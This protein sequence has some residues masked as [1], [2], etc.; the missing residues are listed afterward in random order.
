[1]GVV[2]GRVGGVGGEEALDE[3]AFGGI[4]GD[5]GLDWEGGCVC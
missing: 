1:M 5:V 4:F 2:D 3:G